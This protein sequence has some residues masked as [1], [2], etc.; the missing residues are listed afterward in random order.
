MSFFSCRILGWVVLYGL[1]LLVAAV[2]P[3]ANS[4]N[5]MET[6]IYKLNSNDLADFLALI[7]LFAEVFEQQGFQMPPSSHLQGVLQQSSFLVFVAKAGDNVLGGLT[8]HVLPQYYSPRPAAY[9][10]DLAVLPQ[11]QRQGIAKS[12]VAALIAYCREN[13]F[14]EVY[15]QAHSSDTEALEFYRST[16]ITSEEQVVHFGYSLFVSL[17]S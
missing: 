10:Y 1:F 7:S 3:T 13:G 5:H 15:V 4:P 16:P 9:L 8:V 12:L 14:D 6:S 17:S 2:P 11:Y